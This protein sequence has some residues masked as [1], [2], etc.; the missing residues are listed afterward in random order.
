M[1][2]FKLHSYYNFFRLVATYEDK[3]LYDPN[4]NKTIYFDLVRRYENTSFTAFVAYVLD[5][6]TDQKCFSRSSN[7][8]IDEHFM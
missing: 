2:L 4:S 7:C 1:I 3:V 6:A 8:H 5:A